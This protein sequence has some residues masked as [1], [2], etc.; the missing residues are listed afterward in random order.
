MFIGILQNTGVLDLLSVIGP[1]SF[2][3][4][5]GFYCPGCGGTHA[6]V[7]LVTGHPID[8]FLAHP[9]VIY[10]AVCAL[11]FASVNTVARIRHTRGVSFRML[12]VYIGL[13][14]LFVQWIVK[15]I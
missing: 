11:I 2:L 5:T 8:S 9:F 15:N 4:A 14:I 3:S 7:S 6:V 10:V 12:Y 1:C 13:A